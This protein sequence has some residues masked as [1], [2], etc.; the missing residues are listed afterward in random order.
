[1]SDQL[2]PFRIHCATSNPGKLREFRLAAQQCVARHQLEICVLPGLP[3]IVPCEETGTT[4]E[5]NAVLKAEYYS[6]HAAG[7][8]FAEDS[9]LEVSALDG[10]PGVYSARFSGPG[11]NEEINN[12]LL[13]DRMRGVRGRGARFVCV[14]SLAQSGRTLATVR[15]FVDGYILDE[16]RGLGGFGY[17]PLFYYPPLG[18]TFAE[19]TD[20]EKLQVSHRGRAI[21]ALVDRLSERDFKLPA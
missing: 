18:R 7:L 13:L 21:A 11:A 6:S 1:M 16:P 10:A 8:V 5:E 19:I 17:D 9:G 12:Q 20:E 4:I 14:I 3:E 2:S 15:G